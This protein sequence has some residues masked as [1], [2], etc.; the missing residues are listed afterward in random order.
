MT[1]HFRPGLPRYSDS[2]TERLDREYWT[3]R[4]YNELANLHMNANSLAVISARLRKD[5]QA[6]P[7][8]YDARDLAQIARLIAACILRGPE[9]FHHVV[10]D[11]G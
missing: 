5:G 3:E 8:I 10:E 11:V 2:S 6:K 9:R 7:P 4:Y 1:V